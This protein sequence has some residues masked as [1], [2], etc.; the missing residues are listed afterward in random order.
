MNHVGNM[1]YKWQAIAVTALAIT[2]RSLE[3]QVMV[4]TKT[5]STFA[6]TQQRANGFR[7]SPE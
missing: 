1:P 2:G 5:I 6:I 7:H 3:S 4:R